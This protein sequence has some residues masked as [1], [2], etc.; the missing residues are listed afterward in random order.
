M[1][2]SVITA[3]G[4]FKPVCLRTYLPPCP[5]CGGKHPL[6]Y[7]PPFDDGECPACGERSAPP[8][9]AMAADAVITGA[10]PS[11]WLAKVLLWL[12]AR[13]HAFSQK[14]CH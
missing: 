7:E 10:G 6:A 5:A 3:S 12:A 13:F 9:N 1:T 8:E 14:D 11:F 2:R 4:K